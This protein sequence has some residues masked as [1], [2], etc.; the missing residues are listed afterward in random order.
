[1]WQDQKVPAAQVQFAIQMMCIKLKLV[2]LKVLPFSIYRFVLKGN[3]NHFP[4][5]LKHNAAA[6]FCTLK[7]RQ[8][9][10]TIKIMTLYADQEGLR[11]C[12]LLQTFQ[13]MQ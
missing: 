8:N 6:L 1:M 7:Q 9:T 4:D 2:T 11:P 12:N 13:D 10:N 3:A 5:L